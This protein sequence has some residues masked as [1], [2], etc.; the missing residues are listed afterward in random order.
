[1]IVGSASAQSPYPKIAE[2]TYS[3]HIVPLPAC[4]GCNSGACH[5]AMQGQNGFRLSLFGGDPLLDREH[6][7]RDPGLRRLDL[8]NP[9]N[10]LFLK[11][12]IGVVPHEGG[13]RVRSTI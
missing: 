11:K 13:V 9:E 4:L 12:A 2:T 3:R 5:G 6:L 7:L 8:N 10:S 1:M